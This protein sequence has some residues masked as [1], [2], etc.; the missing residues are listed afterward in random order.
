MTIINIARALLGKQATE[1]SD[2]IPGLSKQADDQS[3]LDP[4]L[5]E[6]A[7]QLLAGCLA[8]DS[9]RRWLPRDPELI[10][11]RQRSKEAILSAD[12]EFK[13][14]FVRVVFHFAMR[15]IIVPQQPRHLHAYELGRVMNQVYRYRLPYTEQ[16]VRRMLLDLA[17]APPGWRTLRCAGGDLKSFLRSISHAIDTQNMAP[18]MRAALTQ[19]KQHV[20]DCSHIPDCRATIAVIDAMLGISEP[21]VLLDTHDDWGFFAD[22][23]LTEMDADLASLWEEFLKFVANNSGSKP[24][25][26]W[27]A[28]AHA[29]VAAI[30]LER[31][32]QLAIDW[33]SLLKH[34]TRNVLQRHASGHEIPSLILAD[35][36][37]AVLK[38]IVWSCSLL[39][40]DS[41]CSALGDAGI[42]S[43]KKVPQFGARSVK[44]GNACLWA[45]SAM[46]GM[47]PIAQLQRL[48]TLLKQLSARKQA[49]SALLS[50][51]KRLGLS[52]EDLEEVTVPDFGL[53]NGVG[54]TSLGEWIAVVTVG[55]PSKVD[56]RWVRADS[57][58]LQKSVPA[59]VKRDHADELKA[60]K[61]TVK[62]VGSALQ[63]QQAR[64]ER[65]LLT[66]RRW[67]FADWRTRYLDHGL[68]S[69]LTHRLVWTFT[70]ESGHEQ[71]VWLE[72]AIVNLRGEPLDWIDAE[73]EVRLWHPI[74][75]EAEHVLAWR[76]WL[77]RHRITQPFKQAHREVYLLT[78]AEEQTETY[79][80]RFAAHILRQHQLN[81]LCQ[82]RGWRYQ[83][84]GGWDSFNTPELL[85][86]QYRLRFEYW[87]DV[88]DPAN[89]PMADS[90]I[91]LY[92]ATDQLRFSRLGAREA[93]PL[94]EI[95][96][97]VF[98]EVLRDVD[99]FVGV[100]SI[101]NDPNWVDHGQARPF[102]NYWWG[103]S[104]GE[105]SAAA[106]TRRA[107]LE[108]LLP[109]L[110]KLSGR[111]ELSGKFLIVR[112]DLRTYKI[113]LGSSNILMEPNDQYL[114]IVPGRGADAA[115]V[116]GLFLPFEGDSVLSVI[117]SKALMLAEDH[118]IK[119]P[120]I[121]RQLAIRD[122]PGIVA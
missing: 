122:A 95:P 60:V 63:T 13:R 53:V 39:E 86:P 59:D 54:R 93:L 35:R 44:V 115:G 106:E 76:Q 37:A 89:M 109:Y 41:I 72:G 112:G 104:F 116:N 45:L 100:C 51:S 88:P 113:H 91:Y 26:K 42:S 78:A 61:R 108:D 75:S 16:E 32:E 14:V 11:L 52:P 118:K 111:W 9:D 94:R 65:L 120:T 79:S 1:P 6:R 17:A 2:S 4:D 30:G 49:E 25:K 7:E 57:D 80:N 47:A 62:D 110:A 69:L 101:G 121:M 12:A 97:R 55:V 105:L 117:L 3:N 15:E 83:L 67:S 73:T 64:I 46:A 96:P 22:Q 84:Q 5:R 71:G 19:L 58:K 119:D 92:V 82:Q 74:D 38:G 21:P 70:T 20:A 40:S 81:A 68:V 85:L 56:L 31:F 98:T 36:N 24:N 8:T 102:Q 27:L 10:A 90:G 28:D 107:V 87:L 23:A 77:A 48:K 50:A 43:F 34:P 66:D 103:Y 33:L 29:H 99:L 18:D 114:C